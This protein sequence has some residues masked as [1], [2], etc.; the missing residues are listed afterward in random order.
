MGRILNIN[1]IDYSPATKSLDLFVAGC[2]QPYCKDCCNPELL[3]FKNGQEWHAWKDNIE[4]YLARFDSLVDN[5][6]LLG[7][8]FNH[9]DDKALEDILSYL[10]FFDKKIWLFAREDLSGVK[11]IFKKYCSYIKCGAYKPELCCSDNIQKG[12]LLATANQVI[13]EKGKDYV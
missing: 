13:Y 8:S 4:K 3:D 1:Y 2:N 7:G 12:V 10:S 6:F 9:Q 11:P 5:I